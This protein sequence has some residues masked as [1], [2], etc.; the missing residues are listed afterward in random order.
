[1]YLCSKLQGILDT[2]HSRAQHYRVCVIEPAQFAL[3][4]RGHSE[5]CSNVEFAADHLEVLA[6]NGCGGDVEGVIWLLL[7]HSA[8][9]VLCYLLDHTIG[10]AIS[11]STWVRCHSSASLFSH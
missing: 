4:G 8:L 10:I 7:F 3:E 5:H 2:C 6:K 1:M 9:P 11:N